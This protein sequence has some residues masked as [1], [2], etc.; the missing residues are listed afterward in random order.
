MQLALLA[1]VHANLEALE[2]VLRDLGRRAPEAR[3]VCAGD[4]VGYGPDPEACLSL[5]IERDAAMVLGN[6]E[7]MVLG[8]RPFI[9]CVHAGIV[10]AMWTR[11]NLSREALSVLASLPS[12]L[13]VAPRVVV[14]HGDLESAGTYVSTES[15]AMRALEQLRARHP[16]ANVL[17]CGHTHHAAVFS[18]SAGLV[19]GKLGREGAVSADEPTI[20]N[21]GA[22]G[23]AR[24]NAPLARYA[25]LDVDAGS[26][27]FVALRY[28]HA[29]TLRKLRRAGL[30]ARVVMPPPTGA[31]RHVERWKTRW[32]QAWASRKM[33]RLGP[34]GESR[35][36]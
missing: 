15:R 17:V 11:E 13:E 9:N 22:V 10:A 8:R 36:P 23:Q 7:E 1:D 3:V 27:S 31:A 33:R 6:H 29:T 34:W 25:L 2:A 19:R 35:W 30:V 26:V 32:A 5:L 20:I 28:D 4:V 24:D 21:P 12:A 16:S 18:P 14:C